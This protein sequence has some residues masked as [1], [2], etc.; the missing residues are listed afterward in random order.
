M[1]VFICCVG[2]PLFIMFAGKVVVPHSAS[3]SLLKDANGNIVG[4]ELVAQAFTQPEYLWPR[5]S[6]VDYNGAKAGG[7][8]K[9]PTNPVLRARAVGTL[10]AY[11]AGMDNPVPPD[12]VAA[13]GSGLDPHITL[14]GAMFQSGRIAQARGITEESVKKILLDNSFTP[15]GVFAREPIVN[16]LKANLALDEPGKK[17]F[18]LW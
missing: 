14:K 10:K 11:G 15:G 18:S 12:L 2:Y 9:S 16:V 1:T 17:D 8:N 13:S 4:S 5:P 6:A 3:G 7:S